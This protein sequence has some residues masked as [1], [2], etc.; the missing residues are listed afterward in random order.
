[1]RYPESFPAAVGSLTFFFLLFFFTFAVLSSGVKRSE[2]ERRGGAGPAASGRGQSPA[3]EGSAAATPPAPA[4]SPGLLS[5]LFSRA[6]RS[7]ALGASGTDGLGEPQL[8]KPGLLPSPCPCSPCRISRPKSSAVLIHG[9]AVGTVGSTM[10]SQ[11]LVVALAVFSSFTQVVIEASS[12]WSLGMNPMNPMNPVQ[13]SEVYIIGAQPLCSQLAGLSQGQKKLC[14]LY[15]DHMQ[16]IGEGA[17]TGI[18]ECQYQFRHRRW[19]CSTVDNNSVFGRVM[20]IGSRETAFTYA[21]SAAGVVNAMSRAC[22]EGELSSCGCSRAARPKDL[23][24][25]WLWGGCGDN[26][27]YGYRFAKEFVDARERERVYQRGSY[28]SARIMMNLHNNEAGRRTVYNLAD[29]A[30]KCHGV[31]GSCSLKTC[32]L[33]LADFRKVG[34][35]LK[36]KYDSAAAMKL[37]SRGKLVQVNSRFNAPTI[38]D[39]VYID[40]SPDYCVRNESTGS[41]GTQGR[42]CNK[43]SE[44]MDGC[45]LMCCGRGYDQFKTVQRER[46]HCKFHWCCYVKCKLCTEI[47]DQF[48]CK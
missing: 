48:V 9:G 8:L 18:K 15:Q 44:G 24:R 1:M 6:S 7:P 21:V 10:A 14:Q 12:W 34:D 5:K 32:W 46:C 27:E 45:E 11:Y 31:S 4:R 28:E 3:E 16:F 37:N 17:K 26:I 33:Q 42:L 29:V 13:M 19:N 41:L 20:Q 36:E 47:V 2:G 43:T 38:H 39:L 30:C 25:D 23:P 40:P 22:R 35:A